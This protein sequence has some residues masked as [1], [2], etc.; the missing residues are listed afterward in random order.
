MNQG[1]IQ[2][3]FLLMGIQAKGGKFLFLFGVGSF[4]DWSILACAFDF[5]IYLRVDIDG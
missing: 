2:E 1:N 3:A 5:I 4:G